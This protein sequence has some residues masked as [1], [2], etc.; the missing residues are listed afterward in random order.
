MA[1]SL[2]QIPLVSNPVLSAVGTIATVVLKL[3][4][5]IKIVKTLGIRRNRQC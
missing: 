1:K 2:I 4:I 3:A 5:T